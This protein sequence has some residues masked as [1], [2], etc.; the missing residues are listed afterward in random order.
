MSDKIVLTREQFVSYLEGDLSPADAKT[1]AAEDWDSLCK[2]GT[3]LGDNVTLLEWLYAEDVPEFTGQ[4][5]YH[6]ARG[7]NLFA[8]AF[9]KDRIDLIEGRAESTIYARTPDR[10][11]F[12]RPKPSL[13]GLLEE[14]GD[15]QWELGKLSMCP[16]T[17]SS[18]GLKAEHTEAVFQIKA[19]I[20][21][22]Y[23]GES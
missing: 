3:P 4:F 16:E 7:G 15:T 11:V 22:H 21:K 8:G 14:L 5:W 12:D 10:P 19:E 20:L 9:Y 23:G 18:T 2:L 17:M 13:E 1:W 6:C